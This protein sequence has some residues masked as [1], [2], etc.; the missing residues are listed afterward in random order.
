MIDGKF[1]L[2]PGKFTC[3]LDPNFPPC[4]TLQNNVSESFERTLKFI[5]PLSTDILEPTSTL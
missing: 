1:T 5:R 2:T 3:R 4:N